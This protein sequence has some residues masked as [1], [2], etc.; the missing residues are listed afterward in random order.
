MIKEFHNRVVRNVAHELCVKLQN[1]LLIHFAA[2]RENLRV[3]VNGIS[4]NSTV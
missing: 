1:L 4:V 2:N 3:E